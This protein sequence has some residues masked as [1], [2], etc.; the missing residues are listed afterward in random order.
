[1]GGPESHAELNDGGD[2]GG[3]RSR[4]RGPVRLSCSVP[5]CHAPVLSCPVLSCPVPSC[6]TGQELPSPYTLPYD[7]VSFHDLSIGFF[8][9][10][11]ET[12]ISGLIA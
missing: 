5:S 6:V 4:I 12:G 2:G 9:A 3:W 10:K 7:Q 8:P 1:M 11:G